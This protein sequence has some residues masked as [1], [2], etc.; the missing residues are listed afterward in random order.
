MPR[1]ALDGAQELGARARRQMPDGGARD[2]EAELVN[3]IGGVG[4]QDHVAGRRDGLRHVGEAFLRAQRRHDVL[5]GVEPDAEPALVVG[6]LRLAQ[7]RNALG[8][9]IAVGA[10]LADGLDHLV[11]DVLRRRHVRIAHAEID[12]VGAPC[13]GRGLQP[14]D[15][16]EDVRRQPLDAMEIFDHVWPLRMR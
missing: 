2:D 5:V 8:G 7:P 15:L 12:D 3:G 1:R 10:R 16:G 6:R 13:T 4:H 11:D 14:I 9:R